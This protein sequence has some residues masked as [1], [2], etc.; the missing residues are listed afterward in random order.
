[1]MR[2]AIGRVLVGVGLVAAQIAGP[3]GSATSGPPSLPGPPYQ[4]AVD[5]LDAAVRCTENA[6]DHK[7]VVL[8][9]G[10]GF[11]ADE[12]WSWG[13][14][15]ALGADGFGVCK[16][17]LPGRSV[18]SIYNAADY[19]VYAIRKAR[20]LSGQKVSVIGHSQGGSH[21]LWA[22]KFWPDVRADVDDYIGLAPGVNGTQLGNIICS[23]GACADIS[24]QVRF[25]ST[26][27]NR[28]HEG[29]LPE[30]PSY[31]NVYTSVLD[32]IV[33]P[34]PA[35]SNIPGGS[36]IAV[37]SICPTRVVEHALIIADSV[38]Y[39]VA[40]DAL[41]NPGPADASRIRGRLALCLNPYLPRIDLAGMVVAQSV[42][43]TVALTQLLSRPSATHEPPLPA[44][45]D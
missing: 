33:F 9:H 4:T 17:D 28:L 16:V 10:T 25:G 37:Q 40:L 32:E 15:R 19:V 21:P 45:A 30:G 18:V 39:A 7:T 42:G 6:A 26:Y 3:A 43:A 23:V 34:Q 5:V 11:T 24:W 29:G 12:A 13:F 31:T 27:L 44:Y 20:A 2:S 14:E 22:M 36:N 41:S 1:M 8:V 38:A 35:A